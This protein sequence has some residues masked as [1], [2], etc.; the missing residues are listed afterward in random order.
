[1]LGITGA[2]SVGIDEMSTSRASQ[3]GVS[4]VLITWPSSVSGT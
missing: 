3:G 4:V 2:G 1:M